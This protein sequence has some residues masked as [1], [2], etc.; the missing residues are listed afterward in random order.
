MWG[1]DEASKDKP[2]VS[3]PGQSTTAWRRDPEEYIEYTDQ[4]A[5]TQRPGRGQRLKTASDR[6]FLPYSI[7]KHEKKEDGG[8]AKPLVGHRNHQRRQPT[9]ASAKETTDA[10]V[11]S[12]GRHILRSAFGEF[13]VLF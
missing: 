10:R 12:S 2:C 1:R 11:V 5:V 6:D 8:Y 4:Y 3:M 9:T 7:A 13:R